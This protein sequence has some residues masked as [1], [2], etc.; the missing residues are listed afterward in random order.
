MGFGDAGGGDVL[1]VTVD[2]WVLACYLLS[3][4][5]RAGFCPCD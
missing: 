2:G 4:E 1:F 5:D 3:G